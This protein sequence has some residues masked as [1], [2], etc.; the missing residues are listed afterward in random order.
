MVQVIKAEST[1]YFG[2]VAVTVTGLQK[3]FIYLHV[4]FMIHMR[5]KRTSEE[6]FTSYQGNYA[7]TREE[8]L[9]EHYKKYPRA[10][11]HR[12]RQQQ[13]RPLHGP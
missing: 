2:G 10:R 5:D 3:K 6:F 13:A 9:A 11:I 8:L 12:G 7:L 4:P 1:T